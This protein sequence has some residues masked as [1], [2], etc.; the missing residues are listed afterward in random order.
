MTGSNTTKVLNSTQ[1]G[2]L[3]VATTTGDNGSTQSIVT[4]PTD[5]ATN[6]SVQT[7][8][9]VVVPAG[10]SKQFPLGF[11]A[12][13]GKKTSDAITGKV[14]AE[15]TPATLRDAYSKLSVQGSDIPL[16]A[17]NFVGAIAPKAISGGSST[18]TPIQAGL[19]RQTN[20]VSAFDGA[21]SLTTSKP[22][23]IQAGLD[24]SQPDLALGEI[25]L[26][27]EVKLMNL[28]DESEASKYKPYGKSG[29]AKVVIN[30]KINDLTLTQKAEFE[31]V[32][33]VPYAL[34]SLDYKL[35]GSISGEVKL[36]GGLSGEFGYYSRAWQEVEVE[37]MKLLGVSGKLL[38]LE[39]KDKIGKIPLAGLV[40]SLPCAPT[41]TC[42]IVPGQTQTP[43]RAAAAGGV[44]VWVY[45]NLK[46]EITF[47]G[48]FGSRINA[49]FE[50]GAQ[51]PKGGELV[52]V[53]KFFKKTADKNLLEVPF[54]Q[55]QLKAQA[56]LGISLD[57][58]AFLGGVRFLNLALDAGTQA[59]LNVDAQIA[60][61]LSDVGQAWQWQGQTCMT[62]S[63]GAGLVANLRLGIGGEVKTG[64]PKIDDKL[65][66][67]LTYELHA[68]S[69]NER[70]AIGQHDVLGFPLWF[71]YSGNSMCFPVP[72]IQ[73]SS[74]SKN[75]SVYNWEVSG[76][77]LPD[78][79]ELSITSQGLCAT[80]P[81]L[82]WSAV[83]AGTKARFT[84]S[85]LSTVSKASGSFASKKAT[86]LDG[87]ILWDWQV[88]NSQTSQPE[89]GICGSSSN[90]SFSSTPIANLC[91][92]GTSS[93][94]LG[95]G[96]WNWSCTGSNGG[97]SATCAASYQSTASPITVSSLSASQSGIGQAIN[98]SF[99]VSGS[100]VGMLRIHAG[101]SAS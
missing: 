57:T 77:N 9:T 41:V 61:V 53:F 84:C 25:K 43:L 59:N 34:S 30:I 73:T 42:P 49:G 69:E 63:V 32:L 21:L 23:G 65:N 16:S 13:I 17:E 60:N 19:L 87:Q 31:N 29:D 10:Q 83:D 20:G 71:T 54:I 1:S 55:G 18:P 35:K 80:K 6:L 47:E 58:D 66:G 52:Q 44:I 75:G 4:L 64:W 45:L 67:R 93:T 5:V 56:N 37:S 92:A 3:T 94:V 26:E 98:G 22:T 39:S 24:I 8:E 81:Q 85:A 88:K 7:G 36:V 46:G 51:Q 40:F 72:T 70:A 68:P 12:V 50:L 90:A 28:L 79:L 95:T 48:G 76:K 99:S 74:V 100:S 14:T 82:N 86:N 2:T 96:P 89:N 78:D 33:G 91:T 15:V 97:T 62:T 38:G 101:T 27:K 11:A